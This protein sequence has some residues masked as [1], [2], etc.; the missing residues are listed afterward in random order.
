MDV[1]GRRGREHAHPRASIRPMVVRRTRRGTG[2]RA[3]SQRPA[4][5]TSSSP[6]ASAT[7]AT[8][9]R[10]T[11]SPRSAGRRSDSTRPTTTSTSASPPDRSWRW[12]D[13]DEMA[14]RHRARHS[15]HDERRRPRR[16]EGEIA[17]DVPPTHRSALRRA[18]QRRRSASTSRADPG[19]LGLRP[20]CTRTGELRRYSSSIASPSGDTAYQLSPTPCPLV[21]PGF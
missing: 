14:A 16:R 10:S 20:R 6:T 5:R 15:S 21:S 7:D 1:P 11:S 17:L 18:P 3:P 9:G 13:E 2:G 19:G 8:D 4:P 12:D